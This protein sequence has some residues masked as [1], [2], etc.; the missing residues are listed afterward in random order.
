MIISEAGQ[1]FAKARTRLSSEH[2]ISMIAA[3]MALVAGMMLAAAAYATA[4]SGISLASSDRWSRLAYQRAQSGVSDY[5]KRLANDPNYWSACD[6][7]GIG[8]GDGLG[9]TAINDTIYDG[10]Y[11]AAYG[12][13]N[14]HTTRRW[15][16]Y[17]T[18]GSAADRGF[19]GQYTI[20]LLPANGNTRCG[21]TAQGTATQRMINSM[22]GTFRIRST[23]RAGPPVPD[24]VT[25]S[26]IE[27]WRAQHW[28]K[29]SIVTEFRR[30]GFLDYVYF[31]DH[32]AMDPA[33]IQSGQQSFLSWIY[34]IFVPPGDT[35]T[36]CSDY[37][38]RALDGSTPGRESLEASGWNCENDRPIYNGEQIKGPF[39]TND[40]S[41]VESTSGGSAP[42]FGNANMGDRVEIYDRGQNGNTCS[43]G[44]RS[45]GC[46][47]PFRVAPKLLDSNIAGGRTCSKTAR[48]NTGV[49]LVTGPD[50]GYIDMPSGNS[51]LKIWAG[52]PAPNGSVYKG[53]T[54]ITLRSDGKY[55]VVNPYSSR[56][57]V[58]YPANGVIYVENDGTPSCDN[59][60]NGGP[61]A[62]YNSPTMPGGMAPGCALVEV[63]GTYNESLTIGSQADI[64]I[65]GNIQRAS[66]TSALLGLV[67]N[68]YVRVR[69][70]PNSSG[71]QTNYMKKCTYQFT[72]LLDIL[73]L[74]GLVNWG[75]CLHVSFSL[76]SMFNTAAQAFSGGI[77]YVCERE[78][79]P[80]YGTPVTNIEAAVLALRHSFTVDGSQC[81]G[82]VGDSSGSPTTANTLRFSGA[83]TQNWRGALTDQDWSHM[84]DPVCQW[85]DDN[86]S[87][88]W[89]LIFGP[90]FDYQGWCD[91]HHGYRFKDVNYDY[92]LRALSPPHFLTPTESAWKINRIRQTAPACA[93]GPKG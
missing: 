53:K 1:L 29:V 86:S 85:F 91:N 54:T 73:G 68:N 37:Y 5:V 14:G 39:H 89:S 47:C 10:A 64:V 80:V 22:T 76:A 48:M 82:Q 27:A 90:I 92:L 58:D 51:E 12:T 71:N 46:A 20:D 9:V 61:D 83:M 32:E 38:R 55:D 36:R 65:N 59:N 6:R 34:S 93:C 31:T 60:D 67:A 19:N 42:L 44:D 77:G 26:G 43:S 16:P 50:A 79:S 15:L 78:S 72:N 75:N 87:N 81:G 52:L 23:G 88:F 57:G 8:S 63:K 33:L 35:A 40:S 49:Q 69:H 24:T 4:Q 17:S 66:G 30:A 7:G 13:T 45:G 70:Y 74:W 62:D 3:M 56:S 25:G 18:A 11:D 84:F 28:K 21:T 2:G 41:I